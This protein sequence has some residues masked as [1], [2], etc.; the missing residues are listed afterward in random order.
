MGIPATNP[1]GQKPDRFKRLEEKKKE[2]GR[3]KEGLMT[4]IG[5]NFSTKPDH[6]PIII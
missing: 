3:R 6:H 4:L 1:L 2:R 5:V